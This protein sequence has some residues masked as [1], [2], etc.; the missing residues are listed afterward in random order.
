MY[1]KKS[2]Y[3]KKSRRTKGKYKL[4]TRARRTTV[5]VNRALQPFAQ[6]YLTK[7]KYSGNFTAPT[8]NVPYQFSLNSI[9]DPD[10]TGVGHQPYG[11]DQ[12]DALYNRYRVYAVKWSIRT[13]SSDAANYYTVAVPTN[14]TWVITSFDDAR[15]KP[16]AKYKL[17]YTNASP[18]PLSGRISL[19]SL[20]GR[21]KT[22]YMADDRYQATFGSSPAEGAYL[23]I[24]A[25][26]MNPTVT[27]VDTYVNVVLYFT[28]ECFDVKT[29]AQS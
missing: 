6:R 17:Q 22:Q 18:A 25:Q 9:F 20:T 15:E 4:R 28:V 3:T 21:T 11:H 29:I 27:T 8:V 12:L 7:L 2:R 24:C 16:R 10:I 14:D 26:D 13:Q 23:T 5:N 19:P 1:G